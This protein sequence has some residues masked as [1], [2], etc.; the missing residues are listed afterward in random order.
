MATELRNTVKLHQKLSPPLFTSPFFAILQAFNGAAMT[1]VTGDM[2]TGT[3]FSTS[4][5][6]LQI[7]RILLNAVTIIEPSQQVNES[8]YSTQNLNQS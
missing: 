1:M 6:I 3:K 5:Y 4:R 2:K 7:R 8:N